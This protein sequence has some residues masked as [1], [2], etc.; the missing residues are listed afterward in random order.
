MLIT[1]T[2]THLS[3]QISHALEQMCQRPNIK[4][5]HSNLWV[6][7]LDHMTIYNQ[8]IINKPFSVKHKPVFSLNSFYQTLYP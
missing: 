1:I 4:Q 8:Q 2:H 6:A 5:N 3:N 7:K